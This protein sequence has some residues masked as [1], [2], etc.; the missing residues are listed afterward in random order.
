MV[1]AA[2]LLFVVD[3]LSL[4]DLAVCMITLL[5]AGVGIDS[6]LLIG[7]A[8]YGGK[9]KIRDWRSLPL[10]AFRASLILGATAG[11]IFIVVYPLTLLPD[12]LLERLG[13]VFKWLVV[14]LCMIIAVGLVISAYEQF[15]R[16]VLFLQ[17]NNKLARTGVPAVI[18]CSELH[19]VLRNLR[20]EKV[21]HKYLDLL[22][23]RRV[24]L[25][26][27]YVPPEEQR[28]YDVRT[29]ERLSK[30]QEYWADLGR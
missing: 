23:F 12:R 13:F 9:F 17:D 30:L 22:L 10:I 3:P 29:R 28:E 19:D 4:Y 2:M 27:P 26:G 7:R 14:G 6:M 15:Q 20:S 18:T 8:V 11:L 24:E 21:R 25:A 1:T 16:F 5:I